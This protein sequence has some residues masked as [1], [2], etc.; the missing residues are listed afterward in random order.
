VYG[1]EGLA[2][3]TKFWTN[4]NSNTNTAGGAM[5]TNLG[6]DRFLLFFDPIIFF[7]VW[8][9]ISFLGFSPNLENLHGESFKLQQPAK[10]LAA[11]CVKIHYVTRLQ[12]K[13]LG[14]WCKIG[15]G[16]KP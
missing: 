11:F 14:G 9:M 12:Q 2:A 16:H 4:D 3:K 15:M 8:G 6:A 13:I 7:S 10:R 1:F 5:V